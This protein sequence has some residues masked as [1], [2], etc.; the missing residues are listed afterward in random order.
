MLPT[1]TDN[2][3][4]L[5]ALLPTGL[6]ALALGRAA[7]AAH[8]GAKAPAD[9]TAAA[10]QMLGD[11]T[12]LGT[13]AGGSAAHADA[14]HTDAAHTGSLAEAAALLPP[15]RSLVV[16]AVDGLGTANL[17]ARAGHAPVLSGLQTRRITTVA[18]STTGAALTTLATGRLPGEHGLIGYRIMHPQLGLLSP[19]RD[20][21]GITDPRD[22]QLA[23][24]LFAFAQRHGIESIAC[25][26]P[27]HGGSGLTAAILAGAEYLGGERIADRFSVA[28]TRILEGA[29][30]G[31]STLAYVYID[32]LDRAGHSEGWQSDAWTRRLEQLDS[33]LGDFLI[34][35]PADTGVVLT[36][37]HGMVDIE[38]SQRLVFDLSDPDFADVV[39][40]GGEPRFRTF[41]LRAGADP[42]A[43]ADT[44]NRSEGKRAWVAT[45]DEAIS[46]GLFGGLMAPGVAE[47]LGDVILAARGQCA[48]YTSDDAPASL[49]MVGQHGSL[50]DE[51]RGIPLA[52]AGAFA[53]SGFA[54]AVELVA[55]ASA[56]AA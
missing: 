7:A 28:K 24:P 35:L 19:L 4:R 45:R 39:A 51:E 50:T 38:R 3:G 5:A 15:I 6:A 8:T 27:A 25:G 37:D 23:E 40:V 55:H 30:C 36:A 2:G 20:W 53:G 31:A 21:E 49:E 56:A 48:Y 33:T 29:A 16:I 11:A 32:E 17:K 54:R 46:A 42:R 43:F 34:G 12:G 18:P 9:P 47:R 22:W 26:R 10:A 1:A 14:A 13:Q 52:L 41:F 44:L